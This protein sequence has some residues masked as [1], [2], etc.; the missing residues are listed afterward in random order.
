LQVLEREKI[1]FQLIVGTSV[2]SLIGAMYAAEPNA[3][4]LEW[5]AYRIEDSDVFYFSLFSVKTGPVKGEAIQNYVR[6]NIK[7]K[8]IEDFKIPYIAI[9]TDLI[10]VHW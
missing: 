7:S 3:F 9:A 4:E 10:P 1:P 5:K 8:N 6:Q 2:G